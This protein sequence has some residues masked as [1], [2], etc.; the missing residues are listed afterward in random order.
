[1]LPVLSQTGLPSTLLADLNAARTYAQQSLSEATR[2][3][4]VSDWRAFEGWCADRGVEALPASP[5]SVAAFLAAMA[6]RGLRPATIARRCAAV[7]HFH[8]VTGVD[9]L[10]TDAAIVKTTMKGLRRSLGAAQAKKAP[11]TNVVAKRLVDSLPDDSLKGRRDRALLML[12][13]AGAFRKSE[14]VALDV[15]DLEFVDEGVR[16]TIRRSKT[17]QEAKGQTIAVLRGAGPFCPVRLLREW[18]DAAGIVDGALFR[19]V[20]KGGKRVGDRLGGR[21]YYDVIKQG[22][23]GI[24]LDAVAAHD[25]ESDQ[26]PTCGFSQRR[27]TV[28]VERQP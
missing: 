1:M 24:G 19:Q 15:K 4:Y 18:L 13:F 8:R 3:A 11:A 2:T 12:G 21:A 16:V 25:H 28:A 20:P 14:F 9:P 26:P 5:A 6:E 7:R 22:I 23:A 27:A 10:P 17:D